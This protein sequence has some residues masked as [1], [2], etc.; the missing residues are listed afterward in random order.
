MKLV[1]QDPSQVDAASKDMPA[2]LAP[3]RDVLAGKWVTFDPQALAEEAKK[4]D[5]A[6]AA[7]PSPD[8]KPTL[9]PETAKQF[10]NSIRAVL[11]RTVTFED[12]GE[13]DGTD[14]VW[15][16]APGRQLADELPKALKPLA[17][18]LPGKFGKLPDSVPA[19]VRETNVT[20]T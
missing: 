10:T 1:G 17:A 3:L 9:D 13:K 8:G 5:G 15:M 20:S 19:G 16:S 14:H 2:E 11:T 7:S 18:K 4:S 6:K 12:K